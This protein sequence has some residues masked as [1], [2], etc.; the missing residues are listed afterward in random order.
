[1]NLPEGLNNQK[2]IKPVIVIVGPTAIGK[3]AL[4]LQLAHAYNAEIISADSRQIYK[5]MNIGTAK[6]TIQEMDGIPHHFID[7]LEPGSDFSSGSFGKQARNK[8]IHLREKGK[9][10][11]VV[12]G[13][14]LYIKALLFGMISFDKKDENIRAELLNRLKQEG[15]PKLYAELKELDPELAKRF[16]VKDTQRILRGL[17]VFL[18][19]G[20]KLSELQ[21]EEEI[22]APFNFVQFGLDMDRA[23]L[24][25]R[26]NMRVDVMLEDGLV[27]EVKTLLAK[28]FDKTNALNAVGYKEVI[29]YLSGECNFDRM[30]ELIKQN[31]RRFAKRQLTWFRKDKTINWQSMQA[32]TPIF[33][34]IAD[35]IQNS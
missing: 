24:Y 23:K 15:L 28:G 3:T 16:S 21:K 34:K 22:P 35:L 31:T 14:G 11:I 26:I 8:I 32:C 13:S 27:D 5:Y 20:K 10:I 19:S 33:N 6:P 9:N 18:I 2:K 12:G 1:M 7:I 17:E 25:E 30:S 29:D 4:S